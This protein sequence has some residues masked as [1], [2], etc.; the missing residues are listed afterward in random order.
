MKSDL[1]SLNI[2]IKII[3][4]IGAR[5]QFIKAAI[6]SKTFSESGK[7]NEVIIHTGQHFDFN[8]DKI[9]FNELK[10]PEPIYNLNI[11]SLSHGIMTGRMLIQI[12]K[13]LF[14]EKPDYVLV[15][16]DTN[17]TLAGALAAK[18]LYINLIHVEAG[19]RSF[20]MRMP[21][22]IN[23]ILT[24]RISDLLF[25]PT[26][27][28]VQNLLNEGFQNFACTIINSGDV[29]LDLVIYFQKTNKDL[30]NPYLSMKDFILCTIHRE[31]NTQ[32]SDRLISILNGLNRLSREIEIILPLH[33]RT[34]KIIN[35]LNLKIN[36]KTIEPVGYFKM[37]NLLQKCKLVITDSGGLQKEA[38]FF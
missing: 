32:N 5:P 26:D 35:D 3:T 11:N 2:L 4:I 7:I 19:L 23:R 30:K 25:C 21:E 28:A 1:K 8:M 20:N 24:D 29:M 18:K 37:M 10:I 33:P 17:S 15:Y 14:D 12:E 9:F 13:I 16:G 31:E 36:F 34:R 27:N 38:F 6:L 22:E